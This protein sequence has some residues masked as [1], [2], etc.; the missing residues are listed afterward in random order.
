MINYNFYLSKVTFNWSSPVFGRHG[1]LG[2]HLVLNTLRMKLAKHIYPSSLQDR[3]YIIWQPDAFGFSLRKLLDILYGS[4][5]S[6]RAIEKFSEI[7]EP[8][9]RISMISMRRKWRKENNVWNKMA[10]RTNQGT[11]SR[12]TSR[13]FQCR[14]AGQGKLQQSWLPGILNDFLFVGSETT[15]VSIAWALLWMADRQD[16]QAK[17]GLI[18]ISLPLGFSW[19]FIFLRMETFSFRSIICC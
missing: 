16:V 3:P 11:L 17:V 6:N 18:S 5:G 9:W 13:N 1:Q 14:T 7:L 12:R 15:S 2:D 8:Y 19:Y 4:T 10:S